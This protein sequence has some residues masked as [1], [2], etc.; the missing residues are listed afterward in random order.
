M[1]RTIL[2]VDDTPENVDLLEAILSAEYDI[3][4]AASGSEALQIARETPPDLIL[5]DI[6]MPDMNGYDVCR[7]LKA[8]SVSK[9]IP[10]IFVT[11]LLNPGD[12]TRGFEA[13]AVDYITK[14]VIGAIVRSR[15]KAQLALKEKLDTLEE[16]NSNLKKRLLHSIS[17]IREKT[18]ALMSAEEKV[19][20]LHG[21]LLS[22]ELLSGILELMENRFG[23]SSRAVSELAGDA[24]RKMKLSAEDVAKIRLA[25]L[26]HN[27]GTLGTKPGSSEKNEFQM[28]FSELKEFQ[29]HPLRGEELFNSLEDL[30]DVGQMV[31]SHHEAFNGSG[32]PD[33]LKGDE[34]PVGARLL[35]IADVIENGA[36]SV[37]NGREEYALANAR[38]YAGTLLDP[39]LITY[40]TTITRVMY[41]EKEKPGA[42][43]E[44]EVPINDLISGMQLS[45]E[46]STEAG[47]LLLRK[48]R[49][50]A[51]DDIFLIRHS[52][53]MNLLPEG[54]IWIYAGNPE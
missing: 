53:R 31:R 32:F 44:V 50:L 52:K 33:G 24:A 54:G 8:D 23:V 18:G 22:L 26:L 20:D 4:S 29:A 48:G 43:E 6:M 2:I 16:W 49:K 17:T 40:F 10:V 30:Q 28:T 3:R 51:S 39:S 1:T 42:A 46:L 25:G 45:R 11:A 15:V 9:N 36:N 34:I 14:P 37:S 41:F 47:E 21:Y 19:S 13:G 35:A 5:L 27:V 12:E 7:V 38:R